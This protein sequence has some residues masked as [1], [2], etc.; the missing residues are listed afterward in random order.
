[1]DSRF[2]RQKEHLSYNEYVKGGIHWENLILSIFFLC[3][4]F[5]NMKRIKSSI[6][7]RVDTSN[8]PM[9]PLILDL[10]GA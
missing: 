8:W 9:K 3:C 2:E 5:L 1:V 7:S 6:F 10:V 4:D